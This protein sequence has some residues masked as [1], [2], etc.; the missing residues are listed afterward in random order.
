MNHLLN[1]TEILAILA[2]S[3]STQP[4]LSRLP[5]SVPLKRIVT[6]LSSL[7]VGLSISRPFAAG[8]IAQI[9][10][11]LL[12]CISMRTLGKY[13]TFQLSVSQGHQL[14]TNGPY[15][16]VRHPSYT[17]AQI[18]IAGFLLCHLG[19]GSLWSQWNALPGT[20]GLVAKV[21][22]AVYVAHYAYQVI[23]EV[24]RTYQEDEVLKEE[25]GGQWVAWSQRT[26]W[27]L[28]PYVF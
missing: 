2:T 4:I 27:R 3:S 20:A 21:W 12:R 14:I 5:S 7:G 23:G 17:G 11:T 22:G 24:V 26:R 1:V 25:F 28:F 13:F 6:L 19:N 8:L 10:G 18:A 9:T 15:A 16:F